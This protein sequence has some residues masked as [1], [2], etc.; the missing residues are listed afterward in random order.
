MGEGEEGEEGE[1]DGGAHFGS[2]MWRSLWERRWEVAIA[3]WEKIVRVGDEIEI[4]RV[5]NDSYFE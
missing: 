1:E 3:W 5:G 4:D 2:W